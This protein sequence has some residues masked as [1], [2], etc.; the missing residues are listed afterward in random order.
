VE[1]HPPPL[2]KNRNVKLNYITQVSSGPPTFIIYANFPEGV[3]FS[4]ER[5]LINQMREAF[6]FQGVPIRLQFRKKSKGFK[7]G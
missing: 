7:H 2:H 3:H 5:Y 1:H 4:Y 6:G